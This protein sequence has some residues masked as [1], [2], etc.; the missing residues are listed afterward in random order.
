MRL[1]WWSCPIFFKAE[2]IQ[3]FA[4]LFTESLCSLSPAH[5]AK[6]PNHFGYFDIAPLDKLGA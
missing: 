1:K 6:S 4:L 5:S 3:R 2:N